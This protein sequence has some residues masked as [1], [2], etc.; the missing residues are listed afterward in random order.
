ML[1]AVDAGPLYAAANADD[2]D[3]AACVAV[4]S[5]PDIQPVVAA[6]AVAEATYM[7]G[8]R[9]GA[10]AEGKFLAGLAAVEIEAP[11]REDLAR[12]AELVAT[13]SDFPLGGTDASVVALAERLGTPVVISLDRRHLSAIRPRHCEA[14]QLLP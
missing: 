2:E 13:Y 12:M 8:S 3:H 4:L 14:L 6:M 7:V 11:I 9:L 1:A 5:R 10:E